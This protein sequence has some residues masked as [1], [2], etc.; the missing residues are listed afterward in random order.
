MIKIEAITEYYKNRFDWL[1]KVILE[2][3]GLI[4]IFKVEQPTKIQPKKLDSVK[5]PYY[6]FSLSLEERTVSD[7]S[8]T[9]LGLKSSLVISNPPG[10]NASNY[11][12]FNE[13]YICVFHFALLKD[14]CSV[15]DFPFL[16][17]DHLLEIPL[18]EKSTIKAIEIF[19]AL[20]NEICDENSIKYEGL[21]IKLFEL[22]HFASK[23]YSY[24]E[25]NASMNNQMLN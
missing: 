4:N 15:D 12:V 3:I 8:P 17:Q 9:N 16:K 5:R 19:E 21:R 20:S 7:K 2:N 23:M 24:G 11:I 6:N 22:V 10:N 1:P 18:N 13:G 25:S 14:R